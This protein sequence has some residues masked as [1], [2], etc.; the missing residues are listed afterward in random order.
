MSM[1]ILTG[2]CLLVL[3]IL[4]LKS[5]M[6]MVFHFLL[7]VGV[8]A[9]VILYLNRFFCMRGMEIFV[10][11]NMISLLISGILGFPG[12]AL[13]FAISALKFL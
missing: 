5:K 8:G 2:M 3:A 4:F 1:Q 9:A 13:L 11:L 12:V 7:R 6:Q 10:G